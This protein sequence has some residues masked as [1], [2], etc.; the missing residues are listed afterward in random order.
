MTNEVTK[1]VDFEASSLESVSKLKV[2]FKS[3]KE[4]SKMKWIPDKNIWE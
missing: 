3:K 4:T 2:F 1:E